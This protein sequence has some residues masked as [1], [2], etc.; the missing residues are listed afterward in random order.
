MK[1]ACPCKRE[2]QPLRKNQIYFSAECRKKDKNRRW[3]HVSAEIF[4]AIS[5][6]GLGE[7]IEAVHRS[8]TASDR[9]RMAQT[10]EQRQ[11]AKCRKVE[12]GE[13]L[14]RFQVARLLGVSVW[15]LI[16]WARTGHG[17]PFIK[18]NGHSVRYPRQRLEAWLASLPRS[19]PS[20]VG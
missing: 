17:P 9:G 5:R 19:Q 8:A 16:Y 2:F 1:C 20:V 14:S 6:D 18:I 3:P 7:R 12:S 13:F 4:A 15:A 11:K 10:K